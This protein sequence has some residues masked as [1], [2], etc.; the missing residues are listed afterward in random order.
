M[1]TAVRIYDES[2]ISQFVKA[3]AGETRLWQNISFLQ[4]EHDYA[5]SLKDA[6]Q[7]GIRYVLLGIPEDIGPRANCGL[8]GAALGWQAF[9]QRFLNQPNNQF[10]GGD[11][12]LLLG[13]V[14]IEE[15]Q[16]ASC[17][18]SNQDTE[19]LDRLRQL[20][21]EVD[22]QVISALTPIFAAGL[23]P[24]IIGGGHNNAY[25]I[26]QAYHVATQQAAC[27][28]NFDPHADFRACEGRHSG[29]GFNYAYQAGSLSSYHVIGLHEHK[30]N[31][32][33]LEQLGKAGF[34]FSS[35]QA[36]KTRRT[37]S[38]PEA[39]DKALAQLPHHAPLGVELDVD[40]IIEM[41]ASALTYQGFTCDDAEYFVY[42]LAQH[43]NTK[44]VHLCEAAPAQHPLGE[45][46]GLAHCG[47]VLTSLANAYISTRHT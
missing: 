18:L 24:I 26:L 42:R 43:P 37:L 12:I 25:G 46:T 19:Q 28:I 39:L 29:N 20:C 15:I 8:G 32:T 17:E 14:N 44:Y 2:H 3:R 41:P 22:K 30:N 1:N 11:K 40:A 21:S 6:A 47:Q 27:A 38:L 13:E 9:L 36:I 23:E 7:F 10:L 45:R 33:I 34:G 16:A 4:C 5:A 31:Q 35:Y